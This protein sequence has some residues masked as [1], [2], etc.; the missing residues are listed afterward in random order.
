M[1]LRRWFIGAMLLLLPSITLADKIRPGG[2][3][4]TWTF[5]GYGNAF[6][7]ARLLEAVKRT[8]SEPAFITLVMCVAI[9][10]FLASGVTGLLGGRPQKLASYIAGIIV[11]VYALFSV[12]VDVYVEDMLQVDGT[13]DYAFLVKDVPAAIGLP[14]VTISEVGMW[15]VRTIEKQ[16]S[17][18]SGSP[19]PRLSGGGML[20]VSAGV[21]RDITQVKLSDPALRA[22]VQ[23]YIA[24]CVIPALYVGDI[25]PEELVQGEV[26][27]AMAGGAHNFRQTKLEGHAGRGGE[28]QGVT[29]GIMSCH[30]AYDRLFEALETAAPSLLRGVGTFQLQGAVGD[31]TLNNVVDFV[32]A[33]TTQDA[34]ALASQSA[35]IELASEGYK[36]AAIATDSQAILLALNTE[37]A[38]RSQSTGW[39][40]ASVLFQDMAGYLFAMLQ[41]FVIGLTP[42]VGAILLVPGM[43]MKIAGGYARVMVWLMLWWPGLAIVNYIMELYLQSQISGPLGAGAGITMAN[44]ELI[45]VASEKMVLAS[46]FMATLVPGIMWGI[47]SGSGAAF[48]SA[49]DR[50]SGASYATQAAGQSAAGSTSMGQI[51]MNSTA[52]NKHDT[53]WVNRTGMQAQHSFSGGGA[54]AVNTHQVSGDEMIVGTEKQTMDRVQ[55][56]SARQSNNAKFMAETQSALTDTVSTEASRLLQAADSHIKDN[57]T[58]ADGSI[59]WNR[60]SKDETLQS[61]SQELSALD[62]TLEESGVSQE[63]RQE[64][65][66]AKSVSAGVS[67]GGGRELFGGL[68]TIGGNVS[69]SVSRGTRDTDVETE[70]SAQS[71]S[72][73][74]GGSTRQTDNASLSD[75]S[76]SGDSYKE[77]AG[78][79]DSNQQRSGLV[80]SQAWAKIESLSTQY[81]EA[82]QYSQELSEAHSVATQT[83]LRGGMNHMQWQE[84][85]AEFDATEARL[86]GMSEAARTDAAESSGGRIAVGTDGD[87][88]TNLQDDKFAEGEMIAAAGG[89]RANT[90]GADGAETASGSTVDLDSYKANAQRGSDAERQAAIGK[91]QLNT[92]QLMAQLAEGKTLSSDGRRILNDLDGD[93]QIGDKNYMVHT[94]AMDYGRDGEDGEL[95]M[96]YRTNEGGGKYDFHVMGSDGEMQ[97]IASSYNGF[98]RDEN[99]NTYLVKGDDGEFY[100]RDSGEQVT[101]AN[102]RSISAYEGVGN[103]YKIDQMSNYL[104]GEPVGSGRLDT[105]TRDGTTTSRVSTATDAQVDLATGQSIPHD[106]TE[107][108]ALPSG[109]AID[110]AITGQSHPSGERIDAAIT[111]SE[112]PTDEHKVIIGSRESFSAYERPSMSGRGGKK[113]S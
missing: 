33:G 95:R 80:D 8:V 110:R 92:D 87:I 22:G 72:R 75:A 111:D 34:T 36:Q 41:A 90:V 2:G 93:I 83:N 71:E 26:W 17:S 66:T 14:A 103:G 57:Y 65:Y 97:Q 56:I 82:K 51:S 46:G 40:T 29:N 68:I 109:E 61:I 24:D 69:G 62:R 44:I 98:E 30:M 91:D 23:N 107:E 18:P 37:Q 12:T 106:R 21:M 43:G 105:T 78:Q 104:A 99:G 77:G 3:A 38:R 64:A 39:F 96:I 32:S 60:A 89:E 112:R 113:D 108:V 79:R 84:K 58:S 59:D 15:G 31:T 4:D 28:G 70:R 48:S 6:V 1:N 73:E 11:S 5:Y 10:G 85:T 94:A 74:V 86:R 7:I 19:P 13:P 63:K 88:T 27:S 100:H 55:D 76:T 16:F 35:M 20:G 42:L 101:D 54:A 67:A 45:N 52:M 25:S 102:V 81:S 9:V 50:A 53:S 47:I 49:I